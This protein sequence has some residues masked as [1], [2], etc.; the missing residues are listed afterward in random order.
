VKPKNPQA[1]RPGPKPVW[2]S[3]DDRRR[4][5]IGI[6]GGLSA[7]ALARLFDMPTTSF[8]RIF[9]VEIE[10]GRARLITE[11]GLCLYKAATIDRSAAAA[12]ALLVLMDRTP[13]PDVVSNRW[14]GLAERVHA[15]E[16]PNLVD[17]KIS[18]LDS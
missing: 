12:K 5:E 9:A 10:T 8:E 16:V 11:M 2:S 14:A 15:G 17:F 3:T 6:G 13:R 4:V 1:T 18:D 7:A